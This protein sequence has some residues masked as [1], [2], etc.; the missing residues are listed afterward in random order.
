MIWAYDE[1]QSLEALEVPT[2]IDIFGTNPD[3]SPMISLEGTYPDDEVEKDIILYHCYRTPRPVLVMAH[4]F[5]MGLLR[6]EGA[7]QFIS[8]PGGW[9]DI[10]YE[11]LGD[12]KLGPNGEFEVDQDLTIKRPEQNSPH[13]LEKL[14]GYKNL[15]Q[16][17]G[18]Q[19]PEEEIQWVAEQIVSN[20]NNDG[21]RPEEILVISLDWKQSRDQ[22][23]MLKQALSKGN[24]ES[25][26]PKQDISRSVFQKKDCVTLTNIFSAKGNEATI[27]YVTGFEEV[28]ANPMLIVQGRNKAFTAMTRTRGWCVLTGVGGHCSKTLRRNSKYT[29]KTRT[30]NFLCAQSA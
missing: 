9:V 25:I 2:A 30:N 27:V 10:G 20:V 17:K 26:V 5:G 13:G 22:H 29:E 16:C 4:M 15:V 3:G 21:L 18:F 28:D 14:T 23:F 6:P 24:V 11:I 8:K 12:P 19:K 7:V 1:V